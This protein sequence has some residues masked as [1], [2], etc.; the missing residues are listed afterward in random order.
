M[1]IIFMIGNFGGIDAKS[2]FDNVFVTE[3]D[4]AESQ[5]VLSYL[6]SNKNINDGQDLHSFFHL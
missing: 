6:Y 1:E 3:W 2:G 4:G 5:A